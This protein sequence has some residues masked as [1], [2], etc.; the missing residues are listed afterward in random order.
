MPQVPTRK[1]DRAAISPQT[2]KYRILLGTTAAK[3]V[4]TLTN[5]R[6]VFDNMI[7]ALSFGLCVWA[8]AL[9]WKI[10]LTLVQATSAGGM[11]RLEVRE[12]IGL[13]RMGAP[14]RG[15]FLFCLFRFRICARS[16]FGE[17]DPRSTEASDAVH[18]DCL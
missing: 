6:L 12:V 4:W 14:V 2:P 3:V 8:N 13:L 16:G 1:P 17:R 15:S 9:D 18:L 7:I 10:E 11:D 5:L